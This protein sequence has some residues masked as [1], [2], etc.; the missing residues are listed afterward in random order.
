MSDT[1]EALHA[2]YALE[3]ENA[4]LGQTLST[5]LFDAAYAN[6][7]TL[8]GTVDFHVSGGPVAYDAYL[9][10]ADTAYPTR[11]LSCADDEADGG[12]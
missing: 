6:H 3:A 12:T 1:D 9:V 10:W 8:T 11:M 7:G 2:G 5:R 4:D